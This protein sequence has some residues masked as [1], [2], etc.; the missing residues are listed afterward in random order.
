[1]DAV[2][3]RL[4]STVEYLVA[5]AGPDHDEIQRA[6]VRR[7]VR[8][9]VHLLG[10][11]DDDLREV[12][13]LGADVF[14]Q[15]NVPVPG[16]MEG[17]GLVAIEAAVRGTPVVAS[18]IEGIRDAVVD[19]QTGILV[20]PGDAEAWTAALEHLLGDSSERRALGDAARRIAAEM[21]SERAMGEALVAALELE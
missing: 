3:P 10:A 11:V 20:A 8:E 15:S 13:M 9:R 14:V 18:G 4:P 16:D 1:V 2:L 7:G 6:A 19:G 5:G 17:F 12:V 21:Y